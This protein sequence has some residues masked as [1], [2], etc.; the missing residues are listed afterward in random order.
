MSFR[1]VWLVFFFIAAL[2][3]LI[4]SLVPNPPRP[5]DSGID[6]IVL[7]FAAYLILGFL[8]VQSLII[9]R[10]TV[11]NFILIIIILSAALVAYGG[12]IEVMQQYTGRN[13]NLSD[14]AADFAG[15]LTGI[16][17]GLLFRWLLRTDKN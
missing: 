2:G 7:H 11:R 15:S 5:M 17:S 8:G 16:V 3:I 1:L 14:L 12:L 13:T 4:F 6:D 10:I 9:R